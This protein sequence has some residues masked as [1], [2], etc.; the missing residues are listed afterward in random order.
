MT[1]VN[2]QFDVILTV[3]GVIGG[4]CTTT[5]SNACLSLSDMALTTGASDYAVKPPQPGVL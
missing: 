4:S 3:S 1:S 2:L 5:T